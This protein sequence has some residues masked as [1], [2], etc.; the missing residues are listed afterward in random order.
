ME[1]QGESSEKLAE[2]Q[3]K[4]SGIVASMQIDIP[5]VTD[6][7]PVQPQQPGRIDNMIRR[8]RSLTQLM[9]DKAVC[10]KAPAAPGLLT[11]Q[12]KNY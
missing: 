5:L 1:K 12:F 11:I 2:K 4:S 9:N 7:T 10:R 3:R 6:V 8:K